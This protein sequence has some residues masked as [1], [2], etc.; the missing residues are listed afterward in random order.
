MRPYFFDQY[1]SM[2]KD[3]NLSEAQRSN[4]DSN[5]IIFDSNTLTVKIMLKFCRAG[6]IFVVYAR[7][8]PHVCTHVGGHEAS[9][10]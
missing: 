1:C 2:L 5:T 9:Q 10:A 7:T 4:I 6:N 3:K 8:R